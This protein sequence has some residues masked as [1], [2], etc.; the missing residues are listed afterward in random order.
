MI[1]LN[2]CVCVRVGCPLILKSENLAR[3]HDSN[4]SCE[5]N[6]WLCN[7]FDGISL[8]GDK[9]HHKISRAHADNSIRT[10]STQNA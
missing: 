5:K 2:A 7:S 9:K 8:K 10:K 6:T 3:N 4:S 1:D